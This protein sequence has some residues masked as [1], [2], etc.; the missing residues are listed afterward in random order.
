MHPPHPPMLRH[1]HALHPPRSSAPCAGGSDGAS[2]PFVVVPALERAVMELLEQ[3][4]QQQ[5]RRRQQHHHHQQ[6]QQ[7][8]Q[9]LLDIPGAQITQPAMVTTHI[10]PGAAGLM[11]CGYASANALAHDRWI[12]NPDAMALSDSYLLSSLLLQQQ[13]EAPG[14]WDE[15]PS[16]DTL[17]PAGVVLQQH[18]AQQQQQQ[19]TAQQHAAVWSST[20]AHSMVESGDALATSTDAAAALVQQQ[21]QQE[22]YLAVR[23]IE[24][25]A[26]A[27]LVQQQQVAVENWVAQ[28]ELAGLT[29]PPDL[30]QQSAHAALFAQ[31]QIQEQAEWQNQSPP[32]SAWSENPCLAFRQTEGAMPN[33]R[34][35]VNVHVAS[36]PG[37]RTLE[38]SPRCEVNASQENATLLAFSASPG[39]SSPH[40]QPVAHFSRATPG[41]SF[42]P[43]APGVCGT[44]K[45]VNGWPMR[46]PPAACTPLVRLGKAPRWSEERGVR[47]V[48]REEEGGEDWRPRIRT[49][50]DGLSV[51]RGCIQA[52]SMKERR[53]RDK[54]REGLQQLHRAL[55]P[56][57][58]RANLDTASMVEAALAHIKD[59]QVRIKALEKPKP[60]DGLQYSKTP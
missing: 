52:R 4:Q 30:I 11:S 57:L 53:R 5:G 25:D 43:A 60:Q 24:G 13:E 38:D 14:D 26:T 21:Q 50:L 20:R 8:Q 32:I 41:T 7:Q 34:D 36:P 56:F 31:M 49:R 10:G 37:S 29:L 17:S 51:G 27:A 19:Q 42:A 18:T 28:A 3:Q 6:Q 58:L 40:A 46:E 47:E 1:K 59:L 48:K 55:P 15:L 12:V 2:A 54:I 44:G 9:Q 16:C 35:D 22:Q 45:G 23:T 33:S 39:A